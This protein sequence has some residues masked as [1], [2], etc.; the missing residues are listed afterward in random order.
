MKL[1][2]LLKWGHFNK[3]EKFRKGGPGSLY[4][5]TFYYWIR[6]AEGSY[7]NLMKSPKYFYFIF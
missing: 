5:E 6:E 4:S 1:G 7:E 3:R 2:A